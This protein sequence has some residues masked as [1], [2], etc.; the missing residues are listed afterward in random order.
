[1]LDF[2]V[3]EQAFQNGRLGYAAAGGIVLLAIVFV[4]LLAGAGALSLARR[5]RA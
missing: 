3:Y 4:P 1:M 5:L 2:Y